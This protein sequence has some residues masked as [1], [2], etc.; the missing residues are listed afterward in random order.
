M[1]NIKARNP[2]PG[3]TKFDIFCQ[4]LSNV[5]PWALVAVAA[6]AVVYKLFS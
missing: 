1:K 5:A 6:A 3:K 4:T 2:L